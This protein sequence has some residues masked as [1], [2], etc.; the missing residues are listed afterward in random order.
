MQDEIMQKSLAVKTYFFGL[1][2]LFCTAYGCKKENTIPKI[3]E[4]PVFYKESLVIGQW[5]YDKVKLN[6]ILYDYEHTDRCGKDR[7]YFV[8]RPGQEYDYTEI[9]YITP[10]GN[11]AISQTG[12]DW[13]IKGKK[14]LLNFGSQ[15]FTYDIIRLNETNFDVSI[16]L[17][18]DNDGKVDDL[19]L[20]AIKA[21]CTTGDP[22]CQ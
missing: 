2:I 7:F 11:C 3:E 15:V 21:P 16:K 22:Y 9:I 10:T 13:K 12:M 1:A 17:D 14:L 8:N 18:F 19:E 20:H 5:M 4:E 6:G